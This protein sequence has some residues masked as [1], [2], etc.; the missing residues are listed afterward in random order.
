MKAPLAARTAREP[1]PSERLRAARLRPTATRLS[2]LRAVEAASGPFSV[3]DL[4]RNL[5]AS[6][7]AVI[8]IATVYRVLGDFESAGLLERSWEPGATPKAVYSLRYAHADQGSAPSHR[9]LCRRC[10]HSVILHDGSLLEQLRAFSGC[11]EPGR[12]L[13]IETDGCHEC[14]NPATR[15]AVTRGNH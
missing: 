1:T 3:S 7:D 9:L 11:T 14:H 6:D 5:V 4:F 15:F 12:H 13:T 8:S 10:G 2:V